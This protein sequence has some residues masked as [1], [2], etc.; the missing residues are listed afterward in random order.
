MLPVVYEYSV[1]VRSDF[2]K[3]KD[4]YNRYH[5]YDFP[6]DDA[7]AEAITA[8]YKVIQPAEVKAKITEYLGQVLA[9][10]WCNADLMAL[11]KQ[12]PHECLLQLGIIL[13]EELNI[14]VEERKNNPNR[15]RLVVY[16]RQGTV[17]KR[18]CHLQ[19]IMTAGR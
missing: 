15:P 5:D 3:L 11:L 2:Q 16:E 1:P 8:T 18:V 17:T 9:R 7:D 19:L 13:P 6:D 14:L 4:Y 10:C 12:N